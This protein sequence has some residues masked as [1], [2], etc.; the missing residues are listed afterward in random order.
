MDMPSTLL[1]PSPHTVSLSLNPIIT[2]IKSVQ[3]CRITLEPGQS[4]GIVGYGYISIEMGEIHCFG[5]RITFLHKKTPFFSPDCYSLLVFSAPFNSS[6]TIVLYEG[7]SNWSS[8]TSF[9]G[10]KD[11]WGDGSSMRILKSKC[12]EIFSIYKHLH[13]ISLKEKYENLN[14]TYLSP[15]PLWIDICNYFFTCSLP[16]IMVFGAKGSGKSSFLKFCINSYLSNPSFQK[17]NSLGAGGNENGA[18]LFMN[19]DCGQ[20]EFGPPSIVS[21]YLVDS[22]ILGPSFTAQIHPLHQE[23]VG[24]ISLS[25]NP[26]GYLYA[27]EKLCRFLHHKAPKGFPLLINTMGWTTGLGLD[28]FKCIV[29][30]IQPT[31]IVPLIE[32]LTTAGDLSSDGLIKE[33]VQ[34]LSNSLSEP[35][36]FNI[37]CSFS[38]RGANIPT[39]LPTSTSSTIPFGW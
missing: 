13:L 14:L 1:T 7:S 15:M 2:D 32:N 25:D 35:V 28:L 39:I 24:S 21:L 9:L 12:P 27:I 5:A 17:K 8:L 10:M 16:S 36:Y 30:L 22:F 38:H 23:F 37:N 11:I 20:S 34:R 31:F 29:K 33:S 3:E 18:V 6:C 26:R 19:L 4:I